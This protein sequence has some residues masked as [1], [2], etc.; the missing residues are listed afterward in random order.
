[1]CVC[2][3]GSS[4]TRSRYSPIQLCSMSTR[5]H[6]SALPSTGRLWEPL[7]ELPLRP[8]ARTPSDS[9]ALSRTSPAAWHRLR[10]FS[11]G[12]DCRE[13]QGSSWFPFHICGGKPTLPCTNQLKQYEMLRGAELLCLPP[14]RW[15]AIEDERL[16]G[17]Q[18]DQSAL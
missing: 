5:A 11:V 1:M 13:R 16:L 4:T 17:C 14:W 18:R 12:C 7:P 9:G 6:L 2:W 15:R 3:P 10:Q 8:M